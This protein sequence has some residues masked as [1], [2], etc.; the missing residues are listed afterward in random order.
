MVTPEM[1]GNI[2]TRLDLAKALQNPVYREVALILNL[3]Q[4]LVPY[5]DI[6]IGLES[7][8]PEGKNLRGQA[9]SALKWYDEIGLVKFYSAE[10]STPEIQS[11]GAQAELTTIGRGL[12]EDLVKDYNPQE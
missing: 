10:P 9:L 2:E 8:F 12:I 11:A 7:A 1:R 6:M 5:Q 4:G 3:N